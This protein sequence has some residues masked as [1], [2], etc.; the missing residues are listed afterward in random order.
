MSQM[1]SAN[2][3]FTSSLKSAKIEEKGRIEEYTPEE[4]KMLRDDVTW[5]ENNDITPSDRL[6]RFSDLDDKYMG[7]RKR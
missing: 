7:R 3:G 4:L 5:C 2:L 6:Q 1:E